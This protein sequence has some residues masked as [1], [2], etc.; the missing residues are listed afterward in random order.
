MYFDY[1]IDYE[2]NS[3]CS[4]SYIPDVSDTFRVTFCF[5]S[6]WFRDREQFKG[7]Y[8]DPTAEDLLLGIENEEVFFVLNK[9]YSGEV[10]TTTYG[11]GGYRYASDRFV[12]VSDEHYALVLKVVQNYPWIALIGLGGALVACIACIC[13][14]KKKR[15]AIL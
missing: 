14:Y 15:T 3:S 9:N 4:I 13:L 11:L 6:I 2:A 8:P 1:L 10:S 12:E 7:K 5:G